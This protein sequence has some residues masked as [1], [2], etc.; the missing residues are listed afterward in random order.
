MSA[1]SVLT[2]NSSGM[3]RSCE[4]P[5]RQ[6][7]MH[8]HT[9]MHVHICVY[10]DTLRMR[11]CMPCN[12]MCVPRTY[13]RALAQ[14]ASGNLPPTRGAS[15]ACDW[16]HGWSRGARFRLFTGQR[17]AI[18][19]VKRLLVNGIV[20]RQGRSSNP[21]CRRALGRIWAM[22]TIVVD[23]GWPQAR[24]IVWRCGSNSLTVEGT[25]QHP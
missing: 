5:L 12:T 21:P 23:R 18:V 3:L 6:L 14:R 17:S 10:S 16:I 13:F 24:Q 4:L 8:V 2:S 7:Q 1:H 19:V 11:A 15:L 20:V 9:Y 22:V 25:V